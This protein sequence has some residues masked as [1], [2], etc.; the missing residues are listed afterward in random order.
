LSLFKRAFPK[1]ITAPP[2]ARY[3]SIFPSKTGEGQKLSGKN[4]SLYELMSISSP[5]MSNCIAS[6]DRKVL[7]TPETR[8]QTF[9][10][11]MSVSISTVHGT[12]TDM[13][14]VVKYCAVFTIFT[15]SLSQIVFEP[16]NYGFCENSYCFFRCFIYSHTFH[17]FKA[18]HTPTGA[19]PYDVEEESVQVYSQIFT[20]FFDMTFGTG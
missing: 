17:F 19:N 16:V 7:I 14:S 12:W 2:P 1:A 20:D 3:F 11:K 6:G 15:Y 10:F 18:C 5:R 8:W 13:P 9:Q 4:T